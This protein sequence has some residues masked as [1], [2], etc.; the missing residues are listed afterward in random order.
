MI[1]Q[2]SAISSSVNAVFTMARKSS[3][4]NGNALARLPYRR[5]N[6][7]QGPSGPHGNLPRRACLRIIR[8]QLGSMHLQMGQA[9]Q[10]A[11]ACTSMKQRTCIQWPQGFS[12]FAYVPQ[13]PILLFSPR[14]HRQIGHVSS[15]FKSSFFFDPQTSIGS[16]GRNHRLSRY[17]LMRQSWLFIVYSL[18]DVYLLPY[19]FTSPIN[20]WKKRFDH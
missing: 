19:I 8:S 7:A 9:G 16:R 5:I 6:D 17:V 4:M 18:L 10:L 15:A 1:A 11:V 3:S 14:G 20:R 2:S 12:R 13:H